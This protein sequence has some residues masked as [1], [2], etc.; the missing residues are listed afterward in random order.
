LKHRST[1]FS[2]KGKFT[3]RFSAGKIGKLPVHNL[4]LSLDSYSFKTY[5]LVSSIVIYGQ[6]Q[7]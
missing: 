3:K 7:I 5:W 6:L 4:Q 2:F 1:G